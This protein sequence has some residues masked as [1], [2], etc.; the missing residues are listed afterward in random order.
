MN[1]LETKITT[2]Q[3]QQSTQFQ[4]NWIYPLSPVYNTNVLYSLLLWIK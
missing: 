3:Y 2:V 4:N 1:N